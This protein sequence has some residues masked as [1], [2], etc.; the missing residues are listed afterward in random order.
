MKE[1][2]KFLRLYLRQ[3]R[4][5]SA[6]FC[7]FSAVF[8]LS[9]TLFRLPVKAVLYP[10]LI[11][12]VCGFAIIAVRLA[13]DYRRHRRML[14][15]VKMCDALT[16]DILPAARSISEEDY[17]SV[18]NML[19]EREKS[20][21]DEAARSYS[22]MVD[23]YTL[24]AHQIKTPIASMKLRLQN[25][26]SP[27][28]RRLTSDLSRIEQYVEMAL[29]FLRLDSTSTDYLIREYDLD[30]IVKSAL[31]KFSGEFILKKLSLRYEP[32][33]LTVLT[34]EKWLS[35]VIEQCLS[36][37]L[38]YTESGYISVTVE[39]QAT[40]CV[41]DTGIGISPDDL[42]RI[43]EKG[44]TGRNGR[45]DRQSSGIGLYLCKRICAN[46]GHEISAESVPG[47]GTVIRLDLSRSGLEIE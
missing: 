24:W 5:V 34:D 35:F 15:M 45:Y 16:S 25:E 21:S 30:S 18:V 44:Y 7:L 36:N 42:P 22:D 1:K 19:L 33:K 2:F 32:L 6:L 38:K 10:F 12:C 40:L 39:G 47:E 41:R 46:L 17:Q 26:D 3:Y 13:L 11:C 37:A 20:V 14:D 4:L 29:V 8:A 27:L 43:F 23:Y 31:R 28:S 9:F